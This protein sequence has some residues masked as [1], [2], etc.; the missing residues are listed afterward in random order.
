VSVASLGHAFASDLHRGSMKPRGF[1]KSGHTFSRTLP[2]FVEM[3]QIQGSTWN[4]GQEPWHFYLNVMVRF[5]NVNVPWAT[6]TS[7]AHADGRLESIVPNAPAAFDLTQSNYQELLT[8][9]A[10]LSEVA[11]SVL[12]ELLPPAHER[13]LRGLYS[14]LPVPT[15][16]LAGAA[17]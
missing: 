13:A 15:S 8:L 4:S 5:P 9:V 1:R 12:P 2:G 3:L 6:G 14:P 17:T 10:H 7:A 11:S 16:W